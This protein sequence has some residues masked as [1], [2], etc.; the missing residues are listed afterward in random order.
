[1]TEQ[2]VGTAIR[3]VRQQQGLSLRALAS[4]VGVSPATLS[5]I[6]RGTTPVT[7]DRLE[8]LAAL[9]DTTGAA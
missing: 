1:M 4:E 2:S 3:A 7:V 5:G 9:L 8:R 6:E